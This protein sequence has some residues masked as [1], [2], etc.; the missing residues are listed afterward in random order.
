MNHQK[1]SIE[2]QFEIKKRN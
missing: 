2:N 1:N